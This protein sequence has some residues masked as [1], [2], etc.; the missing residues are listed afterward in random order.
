MCDGTCERMLKKGGQRGMRGLAA[1]LPA[2]TAGTGR[3]CIELSIFQREDEGV[4]LA[5]ETHLLSP[6]RGC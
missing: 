2:A 6:A 5:A 3:G 1:L 4:P